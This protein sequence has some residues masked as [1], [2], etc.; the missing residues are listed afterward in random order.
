[1]ANF[2]TLDLNLLRVLAALLQEENVTRAA[3]RLGLSQ[4]AV[5]AALNRLRGALDDPLFVRSGNAMMATPYARSIEGPLK[6]ALGALERTFGTDQAF[7]PAT[8]T[9]TF[10]VHFGGTFAEISG[11]SMFHTFVTEAPR[12]RLLIRQ[13]GADIART[14][15][16][17]GELD[18]ALMP[19]FDLPDGVTTQLAF[20]ASSVLVARRDHPVLGAAEVTAGGIVDLALLPRLPFVLFTN[21]D[22]LTGEADRILSK[23]GLQRTIHIGTANFNEV[24]AIAAESDLVGIVPTPTAMHV[25]SRMGL[26][27][28]RLPFEMPVIPLHLAWHRR[29]DEDDA[30]RW[31]RRIVLDRLEL[32]DEVSRPVTPEDL[33]AAMTTPPHRA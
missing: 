29:Q 21:G 19:R 18:L 15:L 6:D 9:R 2:R 5:S 17:S 28:Y 20:R 1:M 3:D 14:Q 13:S 24:C 12:A 31:L 25:A 7:D 30:H 32:Q 10:R 8:C 23:Q 26:A 11:A 16:R 4:P 27:I 22:T 33:V